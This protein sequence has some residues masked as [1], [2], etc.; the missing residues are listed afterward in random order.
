VNLTWRDGQ[1]TDE[2][3]KII[4]E[5]RN[6]VKQLDFRPPR[7]Q[8]PPLAVPGMFPSQGPVGTTV[9]ITGPNLGGTTAVE[10]HDSVEGALVSISSTQVIVAVPEGAQTGQVTVR[11][12][13][14][15]GRPGEIDVGSFTVTRP[16]S[17]S[18]EPT[19]GAPGAR[20]RIIGQGLAGELGVFFHDKVPAT[21]LNRLGDELVVVV[22]EGARNGP[23]TVH[24]TNASGSDC[25][26]QT[27][28][29]TVPTSYPP[30]PPPFDDVGATA[31][32][33]A[34]QQGTAAK[35]TRSAQAAQE[36]TAAK[37][38]RSGSSPEAAI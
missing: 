33:Q 25:E 15:S 4:D 12:F 16:C 10:F 18:V 19:Q 35:S 17:G 22:P 26:F 32:A 37:S 3:V 13:D 34:A 2:Q 30:Y 11:A 7:P 24:A 21:I 38:T 8:T 9:T 29:F 31:S 1:L 20:V 14:S 5:Y 6:L 27:E 36:G 28:T 23:I